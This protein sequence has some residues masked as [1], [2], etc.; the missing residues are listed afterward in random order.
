MQM[1]GI[2]TIV[3]LDTNLLMIAQPREEAAEVTATFEAGVLV[4]VDEES[5]VVVEVADQQQ[6]HLRKGIGIW[7]VI[8]KMTGIKG[9]MTGIQTKIVAENESETIGI[10]TGHRIQTET[11]EMDW[12]VG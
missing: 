4:E 9:K 6:Q 7:I 2:W 1:I 10:E 8:D 12:T 5:E 3:L 11:T